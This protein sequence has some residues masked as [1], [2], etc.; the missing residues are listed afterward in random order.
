[1]TFHDFSLPPA[2][3]LLTHRGAFNSPRPTSYSM[4]YDTPARTLITAAC[5]IGLTAIIS[6]ISHNPVIYLLGGP[7]VL[8]LFGLWSIRL[9]IADHITKEDEFGKNLHK[10]GQQIG[11]FIDAGIFLLFF[12]SWRLDTDN[13]EQKR[14]KQ[15]LMAQSPLL[16]AFIPIYGL[17]ISL[18]LQLAGIMLIFAILMFAE[19]YLN[20]TAHNAIRDYGDEHYTMPDPKANSEL[21]KG[22]DID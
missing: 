18:Q 16:W 15:L 20:A 4:F 1:M 13:A 11:F 10:L 7:L 6:S 19:V 8:F 21:L 17:L 3:P 5:L 22:K 14:L 12:Y 9:V 2:N